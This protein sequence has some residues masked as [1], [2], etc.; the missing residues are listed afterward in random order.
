MTAPTI[1]DCAD[2]VEVNVL[3][4]QTA[5]AGTSAVPIDKPDP[6]PFGMVLIGPSSYEPRSSGWGQNFY[7]LKIF[8]LASTGAGITR[9]YAS[10]EGVPEAVAAD[11]L[12][13]TTLGGNCDTF[14]RVS[15]SGWTTIDVGGVMYG[16]YVLTIER[17]KL[18]VTL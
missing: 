17:I 16:G 3:Q 15:D 4:A 10:L 7:S 1:Q 9:A 6:L 14:I 11:L 2:W 8:L 5:L 13:D 18:S 12:G